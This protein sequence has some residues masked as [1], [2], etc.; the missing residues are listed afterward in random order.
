MT[1]GLSF[2]I[3]VHRTYSVIIKGTAHLPDGLKRNECLDNWKQF[4]KRKKLQRFSESKDLPK[5]IRKASTKALK[6]ENI[7][8]VLFIL[9]MVIFTL[10]ANKIGAKSGKGEILTP[11]PH[12]TGH[13]GS[14]P[15]VRK[16]LSPD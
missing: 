4:S 6:L 5:N 7:F 3:P 14:H 8:Y 9:G 1:I 16:T 2:L 13:A 12:T 15:A 11:P 10:G